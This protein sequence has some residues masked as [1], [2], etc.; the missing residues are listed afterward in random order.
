MKS[1]RHYFYHEYIII[2]YYFFPDLSHRNQQLLLSSVASSPESRILTNTK[3]ASYL[4]HKTKI[5]MMKLSTC[6]TLCFFFVQCVLNLSAFSIPTASTT[7][8]FISASTTTAPPREKTKRKTK[9]GSSTKERTRRSFRVKAPG[10]GSP[11][12]YLRDDLTLM[13][14]DNDPFHIILLVSHKRPH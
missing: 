6:F 14:K 10:G 9:F 3:T 11:L 4:S 7:T 13:P 12:E 1:E 5:K 2:F 8:S